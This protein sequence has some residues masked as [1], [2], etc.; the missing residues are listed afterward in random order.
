[1]VG[2]AAPLPSGISRDSWSC[3]QGQDVT[4]LTGEKPSAPISLTKPRERWSEAVL[5]AAAAAAI[6]NSPE[7]EP[8]LDFVPF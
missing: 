2:L 4:S 8:G 6:P 5:P 7:R 3:R 1:M